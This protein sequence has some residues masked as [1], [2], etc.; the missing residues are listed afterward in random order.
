[1]QISIERIS[2][3]T[4]STMLAFGNNNRPIRP[5]VVERYADYMR[6]GE[7][8]A[9]GD[10]IRLFSDGKIAD[11]QHRLHAVIKS[12]VTIT[13]VVAHGVPDESVHTID[14]GATRTASDVVSFLGAK[15]VHATGAAIKSLFCFAFQDPFRPLSN[16]QAS[17]IFRTCPDLHK[18]VKAVHSNVPGMSVGM[19]TAIHYAG[20]NLS[21]YGDEADKFIH[22]MK[23]GV[24]AYPMCA[25]HALRERIFKSSIVKTAIKTDTRYRL[26]ARAWDAFIHR[27]PVKVLR[28][29]DTLSIPGLTPSAIGL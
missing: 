4:A 9:N 23:T 8:I 24:P 15:N 13:T 1:M 18:S 20:T 10:A 11:G 2:P 25:A 5:K 3:Q 17:E 7:W 26:Y 14:I 27:E 28:D 12:G 21:G 29:R 19:L 6:R 16:I 22:V